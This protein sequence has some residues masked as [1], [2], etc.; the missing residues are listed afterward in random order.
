MKKYF[1]IL[2]VICVITAFILIIFSH[3]IIQLF[4]SSRYEES[5]PVLKVLS[6][7]ILAFGLN[8]LTGI[9]LNGIGMYKTVMY[10]TLFGLLV[11]VILN[12]LFIPKFGIMAAAAITVITEYF[13]FFFEFYYL[14][15][16][17]NL[18]FSEAK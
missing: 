2:C 18:S 5:I 3:F 11:N 13:V 15:K 4:Y 17:L 9:I 10:I 7:G 14:K 1:Y 12:I 16:I 8:N 6:V